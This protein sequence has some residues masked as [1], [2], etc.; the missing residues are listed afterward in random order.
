M[1]LQ[2]LKGFIS[3]SGATTESF[4]LMDTLVRTGK[5][6][7]DKEKGKVLEEMNRKTTVLTAPNS[8]FFDICRPTRYCRGSIIRIVAADP[9]KELMPSLR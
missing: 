4:V 1:D 3:Y 2:S 5:P 8:E 7:S 9:I 6:P